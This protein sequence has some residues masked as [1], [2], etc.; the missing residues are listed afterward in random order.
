M[1]W[2]FK[3]QGGGGGGGWGGW[4]VGKGNMYNTASL[5]NWI[6]FPLFFLQSRILKTVTRLVYKQ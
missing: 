3:G 1:K 6:K 5:G 4:L 2:N